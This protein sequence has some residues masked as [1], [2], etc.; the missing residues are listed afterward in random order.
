MTVHIAR[1]QFVAK[2]ADQVG[3]ALVSPEPRHALNALEV[4]R[5]ARHLVIFTP[6]PDDLARLIA[7]ARADLPDLAPLRTVQR[8][9]SINPDSVLAIAQRH[10]FDAADPRGEGFVACLMLN[11]DGVA[12]LK[13]GT[14]DAS[15]P[16]A[17]MLASQHERPAGIYV[18]A[19]YARR[20]L[21]GGVGL[22]F[23][24]LSSPTYRGVDFYARAAT[25]EGADLLSVLGFAARTSAGG[26]LYHFAR[27]PKAEPAPPYDSHRPGAT[28]ISVAVARNMEDLSRVI[29]LRAA[30]YMAEQACPYEEE[31]DGNDLSATHLIGYVGDEPAGCL[32]IRFF[33]D[34]AK[35]ERLAV[36]AEFRNTRL[37]FALVRAGIE[38]ARVKGYRRLYGHAQ[39]RLVGFWSRFG[40]RVFE[41]AQEL[42]FSDF[43]YV[44]M[45][46]EAEPHPQAIAL[47]ADPYV[48]IRPEGR[49]HR[50]GALD[51]SRSRAVT[52]P[53][54]DRAVA[55]R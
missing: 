14:L 45:L 28:G 35:I 7:A 24:R 39:K 41:G 31:F 4:G 32:R 5:I 16:P 54:V 20:R 25:P 10:R 13:A 55:A 44:E 48:I 12:A 19:V 9:M 50:A 34:F 42:V 49:W 26:P 33:A 53:S 11:A 40:F 23:D 51:R 6:T 18:W 46:M 27:G 8:V 2:D 52:R 29:A 22:V 3:T 1:A 37:S 21:S 30:V 43:D 17:A 36:R 38:L 47:G 15:D